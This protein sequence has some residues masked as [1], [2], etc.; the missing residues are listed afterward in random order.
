M[1]NRLVQSSKSVYPSE[2]NSNSGI[3]PPANP[4]Y[5]KYPYRLSPPLDTFYLTTPFLESNVTEDH[6][7]THR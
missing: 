4:K 5:L 7:N 1:E 2:Q 3:I 6:R